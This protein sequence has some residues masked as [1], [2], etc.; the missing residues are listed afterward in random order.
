MS[1]ACTSQ[2][3][4]LEVDRLPLKSFSGLFAI[5]GLACLLSLFVYFILIIRQ[6][7]RHYPEESEST[8]GSSRSAR[9]QTFLSFADEKE[10]VSKSKSK[11]RQMEEASIRSFDED[12]SVN[13]SNKSLRDMASNRSI[14]LEGATQSV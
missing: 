3:T 7:I 13:G 6:F 1:S 4:K 9:L 8:G 2:S 5:C 14:S 10:E 12:A 11:R